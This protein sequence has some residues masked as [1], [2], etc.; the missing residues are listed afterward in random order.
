M[1][2]AGLNYTT[3]RITFYARYDGSFPNRAE[4]SAVTGGLRITF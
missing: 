1:V 2:G 4:D 3:S